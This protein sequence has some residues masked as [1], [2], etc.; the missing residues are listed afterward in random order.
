M[1]RIHKLTL[2]L[3]PLM[4][5][6]NVYAAD[7]A[8]NI[9]T[10]ID[11]KISVETQPV[12]VMVRLKKGF[13][14]SI[15]YKN[16]L[17]QT[18]LQANDIQNVRSFALS[19]HKPG[20]LASGK[21]HI[22]V[23]AS[24]TLTE[25]ELVQAAKTIEGMDLVEVSR[26]IQLDSISTNA[27]PNDPSYSSLWGMNNAQD[28]DIDAPEA[29]DVGTGSRTVVVGII[30]TGINYTHPD[31]INNIWTNPGEIAG[32]G[33]D[34]DGNG[35]IDDIHGIDVVNGDT[36]PMDD[37]SHG[38]H[39]A[40]TIG[41]E[42]NNGEGVVG[43]NWVV[44]IA[45]CKFLSD[46]GSG[47]TAGAVECVNYFN[48]L[49]TNYGVNIVV[50]NNSWGGG[51]YS[52]ILEDAIAE[53]AAADI[54]FAAAAGNSSDDNDAGDYYPA[55]YDVDSIITVAAT[56]SNDQLASFSSYGATSV[57]LAAPGVSIYSTVLGTSYGT[58]S[59]TSMATPHVAGAVALM[60]SEFPDE[61]ATERK[62]RILNAVDRLPNLNG[63]VITAGRLNIARAIVGGTTTPPYTYTILDIDDEWTAESEN[64][65]HRDGRYA[66]YNTF[67]LT[68]E[69]EVSIDLT[70]ST[71]TYLYLLDSADNI[72]AQDD[73]GGASLNSKITRT[74]EAGTYTTESTTYNASATGVF[75]LKVTGERDVTMNPSIITYLLF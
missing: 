30:D 64:A 37:N 26:P 29:W 72:I 1:K 33:I 17:A 18:K 5:A 7:N 71:D 44:S 57:E 75:N 3:L 14:P 74:L 51:G 73:D 23:L 58:K 54:I 13:K 31:L 52:S 70:S 40:G 49:K 9:L 61:T 43:V 16:F 65:R 28:A 15:V 59:G 8:N 19:S 35:Y 25:D 47:G 2:A 48:D 4:M 12:T 38:S 56:D 6:N 11:K 55:N 69:T 41:A 36:D 66:A 27:T 62:M 22:L 63:V 10:S 42:G 20:I 34:D 39:C 50:T 32:N 21:K 45:G 53:G 46:A 67:T 24:S 68:Q 60:A